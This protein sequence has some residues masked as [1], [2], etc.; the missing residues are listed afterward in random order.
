MSETERRRV[1]DLVYDLLIDWRNEGGYSPE[2]YVDLSRRTR[3]DIV[4]GFI[5]WAW[6][7]LDHNDAKIFDYSLRQVVMDEL[8][9]TGVIRCIDCDHRSECMI[10]ASNLPPCFAIP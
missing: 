2:E 9:P 10:L 1:L 3:K 6:D 5:E 8:V 7:K 4:G